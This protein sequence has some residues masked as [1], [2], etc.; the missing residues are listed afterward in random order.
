M[1]LMLMLG[2]HWLAFIAL[3]SPYLQTLAGYSVVTTGLVLAP[4]GLAYA[5]GSFAAGRLL[6]RFQS[7]PIMILGIIAVAWAYWQ[8]SNFTPTFD[9]STFYVIIIVH[10]FGLGL[11]FVPLTIATF[12]TLPRQYTDIGT[13]LYSLMR[14]FGSSIGAS[15]AVA[16]VVRMTQANHAILSEHVSPF[17][18]ALRHRPLPEAWS[19]IDPSGLAALNVETTRQAAAMA[20]GDDFRWLAVAILALIPLVLL[21]RLPPRLRHSKNAV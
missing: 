21:L 1:M 4:Q 5:A 18:E 7:G 12:S 8:L 15:L 6:D 14:N 10:G 20:Y 9:R 2:A 3:T 16:Y 13:G 19:I 11:Y 17:N